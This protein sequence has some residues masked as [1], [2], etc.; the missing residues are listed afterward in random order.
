MARETSVRNDGRSN[1]QKSA[2]ERLRQQVRTLRKQR[3]VLQEERD[4]YLQALMARWK[5]ESRLEDWRDFDRADYRFTLADILA[6][7]EKEEGVCLTRPTR[8]TSSTPAKSGK[9]LKPSFVRRRK[10]AN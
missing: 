7:F 6:E 1:G 5:K 3:R 8:I 10:R 4:V 2:V 9:R